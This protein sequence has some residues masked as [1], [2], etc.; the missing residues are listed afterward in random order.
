[1]ARAAAAVIAVAAT[2]AV[3]VDDDDDGDDDGVRRDEGTGGSEW[4]RLSRP[5]TVGARASDA[6]TRSTACPGSGFVAA[7]WIAAGFSGPP[8]LGLA[9]RRL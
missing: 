1:M 9:W 2:A 8:V 6:R 3:V 5:G 4:T 7:A